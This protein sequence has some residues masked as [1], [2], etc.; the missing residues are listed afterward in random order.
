M[1][2][3][4][5]RRVR[6][7]FSQTFHYV[8]AIRAAAPDLAVDASVHD[9]QSQVLSRKPAWESRLFLRRTQAT[10]RDLLRRMTTIAVL[11]DKD[12][13]LL[14]QL[15]DLAPPIRRQSFPLSPFAEN[16]AREPG[17]VE[18]RSL[19]FWGAM[20][21]TENERAAL[22][23][24][25]Q[26]FRPLAEKFAD[27]RLLVVGSGPSP[28]LLSY[29]CDRIEVTGFV[30]DPTPYFQRA[31]IG[32]VP[33]AE[34]AGVKLKTLEMLRC[35]LLVVSTEVGAEGIDA[36]PALQVETRE[37]FRQA[38]DEILSRPLEPA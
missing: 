24:I 6:L 27:L 20:S 33:L 28:K 5:Y 10:E 7:E 3:G 25:E 32:V 15:Y 4:R 37:R 38:L 30:E 34:G 13:G 19:L 2:S 21:R 14:R 36:T 8:K 29:R 12:A 35:G 18:R 31:R 16:F 17:Q 11:S 23:F 9:V 26:C 1:G 22:W